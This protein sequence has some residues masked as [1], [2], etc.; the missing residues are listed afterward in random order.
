MCRHH[1]GWHTLIYYDKNMYSRKDK[2][3]HFHHLRNEKHGAADLELLADRNPIHKNLAR[4]ARD[5]KRY[6][7]DI[8]YALL[9][10]CSAE[11]IEEN[12]E[13]C[14]FVGEGENTS[15]EPAEQHTD[16]QKQEDVDDAKE[17]DSTD[18]AEEQKP[19]NEAE[20]QKPIDEVKEEVQSDEE[21]Q[22]PNVFE[23]VENSEKR[24]GGSSEALSDA[25]PEEA[26]KK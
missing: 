25:P 11:E 1:C 23:K 20:E 18:E 14:E 19:I 6:A 15:H 5:P 21:I 8:L 24:D 4:F 13:D 12:R 22:E 16:N 17:Q 9:D 2:L 7:N 26:K 3:N 10:V